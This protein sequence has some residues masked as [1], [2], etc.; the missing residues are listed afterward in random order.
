[1]AFCL[2]CF[3]AFMNRFWMV[4]AE[5]GDRTIEAG[6]LVGTC[7]HGRIALCDLAQSGCLSTDSGCRLS[8]A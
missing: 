2:Q 1:M 5:T 3:I 7:L 8:I 4:V 6:L